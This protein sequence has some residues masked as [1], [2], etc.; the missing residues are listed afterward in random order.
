MSLYQMP[1]L[2]SGAAGELRFTLLVSSAPGSCVLAVLSSRPS[3]LPATSV[4]MSAMNDPTAVNVS[5]ALCVTSIARAASPA[6]L[7]NDKM[8]HV[9]VQPSDPLYPP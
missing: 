9:T 4:N 1:L 6:L 8:L 2:S 5:S 7:S 3:C